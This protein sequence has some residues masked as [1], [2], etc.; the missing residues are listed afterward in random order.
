MT[1][2]KKQSNVKLNRLLDIEK[3]VQNK[4]YDEHIF[5]ENAPDEKW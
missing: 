2:V 4:W 1:E 5:E 3:Q